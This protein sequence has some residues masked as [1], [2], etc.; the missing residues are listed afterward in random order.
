MVRS[1]RLNRNLIVVLLIA[2]L[3]WFLV[4][5]LVPQANEEYRF[6]RFPELASWLNV[7]LIP[8]LAFLALAAHMAT[9]DRRAAAL[10]MAALAFAVVFPLYRLFTAHE[11]SM[12][13][14]FYEAP[15][16]FI[17]VS[18]FLVFSGRAAPAPLTARRRNVVLILVLTGTLGLLRYAL[19]EELDRLAETMSQ[20]GPLAW[21]HQVIES[22]T[23]F[24][25]LVA[26]L[27]SFTQE[28]QPQM[29]VLLTAAFVL[30]AEQ[31]LFFLASRP[32]DS[33]WWGANGLWGA[34][35][36]C[37]IW[38]VFV[39][40]A[41][42]GRF[43]NGGRGG[44]G[45]ADAWSAAA[46]YE[47][48]GR[49]G[50]G[51]MG[52]VFKA[53]HRRLNR[54]V[55]VKVIRPEQLG[56]PNSLRRF[57]REARAAARLSHPNIVEIFDAAEAGGTF[58]LAMEYVDGKDLAELV[59][60]R[61]P[62]PV[63]IACEYIR[64]AGLGL[65][66]AHERGLVH[67]D[68]KPANLL[69]SA[70]G[71]QVKL[72]DMGLARLQQVDDNDPSLGELTQSGAVMGTPAYLAPEQAR[73]S[74]RVDIRADIYSLGC[75]LYHLLTGQAPFRGMSLAEVVLRHQL[76]EPLPIEQVRPG[77]PPEVQDIL[78]KMLAKHPEERY[79][80]PA[81]L[82]KSLAPWA[83]LEPG[84]LASWMA[85]K[86]RAL[87]APDDAAPEAHGPEKTGPGDPLRQGS[88]SSGYAP[89]SARLWHLFI[90]VSL[91]GVIGVGILFIRSFFQR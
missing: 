25:A 67:R 88:V 50:E 62:L 40:A 31:A 76:E 71:S 23:I 10:A 59:Q 52:Q 53:R 4:L 79:Q 48:L 83:A 90:V 58:L 47:V 34:A 27:R 89:R 77:V 14:L 84:E 73:D 24:L 63:G 21:V 43:P 22:A 8:L 36:L 37:L 16:K 82:A 32:F 78:N 13:V 65:Q 75:T 2:P 15:A 61:G 41:D 29:N 6:G 18:L 66:H 64:Q 7:A 11:N 72:L 39:T 44:T 54:V 30:L 80:T 45:T 49:L 74:R 28:R 3:A 1:S 20:G 9:G 87:S 26:A 86:D 51:G 38:E 69:L 57:H 70:D 19:S 46:G 85:G 91:V 55:A 33:F 42:A 17:F 12:T 60:T 5:R 68:I 81:E 56:N 35:T